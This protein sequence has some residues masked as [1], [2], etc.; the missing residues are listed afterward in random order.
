MVTYRLE[1]KRGVTAATVGAVVARLRDHATPGAPP[2]LLITDPVT[3]PVAEALRANGQQFVDRA[4]NAFLDAPGL[5]VC[6]VGRRDRARQPVRGPALTT[7]NGLKLAF[8]LMCNANLAEC[9]QRAIAAAADI[10]LG[11]V[12]A[13]LRDME[14]AGHVVTMKGQRRF[15]GTKRLLDE[16]AHDYARRL[17]P[18]TLVALYRAGNLAGWQKWRIDPAHARW[19]GEPGAALLTNHL[20]P[21][22]LTLYGGQLPPKL[23]VD[24]RL[25]RVEGPDKLHELEVRRPFWGATL[26]Q[27]GAR[28]DVAPPALVYADLL[29]TGDARCIETAQV[30]YQKHLARLLP[31]A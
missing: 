28:P 23:I 18:K 11:A 3:P 13:L 31:Q 25:V 4:G 22:V 17:R 12:P 27:D 30:L 9:P 20:R 24:E 5:Y 15:R 1:R 7:A 6:V 8:A 14:T 10:A 2:I 21:Q 26:K 16:W 29:A 19:G